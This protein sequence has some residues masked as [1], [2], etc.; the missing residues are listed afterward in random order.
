MLKNETAS[1]FE[2]SVSIYRST[3]CNIPENLKPPQ[4][5]LKNS[6]LNRFIFSDFFPNW[7]P[8]FVSSDSNVV[9]VAAV[10]VTCVQVKEWID[11]HTYDAS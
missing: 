10:D 11:E 3:P 6:V 4:H 7:P 5:H 1:S 8:L 2:T 9:S